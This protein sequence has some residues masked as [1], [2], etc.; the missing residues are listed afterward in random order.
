MYYQQ[1][2]MAELAD[3]VALEAAGEIHVGS[4]PTIRTNFT[5]DARTED[6]I[7]ALRKSVNVWGL[8]S[9]GRTIALQAIGDEFESRR[10]HQ[11][12]LVVS[13]EARYIKVCLG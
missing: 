4:N 6:S 11:F 13:K 10:L 2:S 1:A 3:A 8:S 5:T 9:F 7:R 12:C